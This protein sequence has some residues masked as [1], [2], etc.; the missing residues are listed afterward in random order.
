MLM[1]CMSN[2]DSN[3]SALCGFIFVFQNQATS[4]NSSPGPFFLSI[5]Q[6]TTPTDGEYL[7]N[8]LFLVA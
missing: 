3:P 8:S 7:K 2:T 1:L 4:T 5:E 6:T